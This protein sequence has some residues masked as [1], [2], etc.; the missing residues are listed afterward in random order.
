MNTTEPAACSLDARDVS[1]RLA[2]VLAAARGKARR[3]GRAVVASVTL[4]V[5][6]APARALCGDEDCFY[7]EQ[8]SLDVRLSGAGSALYFVADGERRFEAAREGISAFLDDD[9]VEPA[10][11]NPLLFAG[12]AFDQTQAHAPEWSTFPDG[13]VTL[14]SVLFATRDGRS[15]LTMNRLVQADDDVEA[16]AQALVRDALRCYETT[17]VS[18]TTAAPSEPQDPDGHEAWDQ[19]VRGLVES[20]ARGEAEKVV[21]AR[22]VSLDLGGS[23]DAEAVLSRLRARFPDC[24]LF[25]VR[26]AGAVFLGATPET[27]V[28]LRGDEVRADCLAGSA[29]RGRDQTADAVFAA[30]LLDDEK[31]R[32]EHAVVVRGLREALAP[33][34]TR[35]HAPEPPGLRRTA[36]IQHLHTPVRATTDGRRHVLELVERLH[37]TPAT[38]GLP[39]EKSLCL[40]KGQERFSRGWYAGPVGWL[41]ARGDGE[42]AVALR[43]ALVQDNHALLYAG[44]GIVAGSDPRREYEESATKLQAMRWALTP[45]EAGPSK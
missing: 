32:R 40:I 26:R 42:F 37:P 24:T 3:L 19:S 22:R 36:T 33:L 2:P 18:N 28:S 43:S 31:E 27:L 34:C 25:A 13:L 9:V 7:W 1:A 45:P 38:A 12:F 35:V 6:E 44:C 5:P 21:L 17:P 11:A 20:I 4:D 16:V 23:F 29:P 30:R 39:R 15:Q 8:P 14:P 41:D 10:G